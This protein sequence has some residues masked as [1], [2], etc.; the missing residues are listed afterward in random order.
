MQHTCPVSFRNKAVT[1]L[2]EIYDSFWITDFRKKKKKKGQLLF[3]L[4]IRRTITSHTTLTSDKLTTFTSVNS[5]LVLIPKCRGKKP[6]Q[7]KLPNTVLKVLKSKHSFHAVCRA[8]GGSLLYSRVRPLL[9]LLVT[10]PP[11][12]EF[13]VSPPH[14]PSAVAMSGLPRSGQPVHAPRSRQTASRLNR[15]RSQESRSPPPLPLDR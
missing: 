8:P 6:N 1:P 10:Y 9:T 2:Q 7:N 14:G 12:Q 13:T 4:Y 15:L 3:W 11:A 5:S